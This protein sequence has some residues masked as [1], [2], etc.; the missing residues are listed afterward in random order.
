MNKISGTI[1]V[2]R[3]PEE[4]FAYLDDFNK[5]PLWQNDV[6]STKVLTE[7]PTR[8]GTEVEEL[9]QMG[10]RAMTTRWR[11]TSH[12]PPRRSTFE[13]YEGSMMRPSGVITVAPEGEGSRVTFEMD[14]NPMGFTKVLMPFIGGQIRKSIS[15][16]LEKLKG[17]LERG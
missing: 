9:R 14:P 12:E 3:K 1:V 6:K 8:V 11:V 15:T 17:N 2:A 16:N 13:T 10:R 7:G 4:V 5:H